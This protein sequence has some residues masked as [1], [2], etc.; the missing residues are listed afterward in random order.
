M[1]PTRLEL[2]KW[3]LI[4]ELRIRD[5][6]GDLSSGYLASVVDLYFQAH[7]F[8][9]TPD[10]TIEMLTGKYLP[11]LIPLAGVLDNPLPTYGP[12]RTDP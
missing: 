6:V 5:P 12:T 10:S 8:Q 9:D 2:L 1:T 4:S 7:P 11:C 3:S